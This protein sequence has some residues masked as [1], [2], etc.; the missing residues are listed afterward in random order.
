MSNLNERAEESNRDLWD[1]IAPIHFRAYR[2]VGLLRAGGSAL[3]EIELEEVGDVR[4]KTLLHLQCHIGTDTLSWARQGATATGVDFSPESIACAKRLQ[5]ELALEATFLE[6]NVYD[7]PGMLHG[8]FDVVY[9]SRGVLCWLR[10]LERWAGIVAHF[11]K[12]GGIF[13]MMESHPILNIFDDARAGD[14]AIT[15]PYF[16]TAE[17]VFWDVPGP[18]YADGTYFPK[19]KSY[20]WTWPVSDI[21]NALLRAGLRLEL[22]NEFDR[23]FFKRF[24][25]M[26]CRSER[27]Y[28]LPQYA[29]KLPLLFTLRARKPGK[30]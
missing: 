30:P 10:D 9:T 25:G 18:D 3:D 17:P 15:Q 29:G 6:A 28:G 2:E 5:L 24:P 27:W 16:H 12:P 8:R 11:L 4:G 20:E 26:V 23:L 13:Y 14:L 22:F 19:H 7:L 21:I 1:E